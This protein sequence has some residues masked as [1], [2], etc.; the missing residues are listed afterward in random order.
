MMQTLVDC[1]EA[2]E[3]QPR[4]G[5]FYGFSGYGK[6]VAAAYAAALSG[7]IYIEAKSLWNARTVLERLA[8]E[9]GLI[10]LERTQARLLHQIID[11]INRAPRPIIIDEMDHLVKK[12][13]VDVIRDIHDATS[14]AILMIGEEALPTKLKEWD[15]F[16][17][18]ILVAQPAQPAS[19]EDALLLRNHYGLADLISDDLAMYFA[20]KCRGVT[21]RIVNNLKAAKRLANTEGVDH[22]D[23]LWWGNRPVSS[24]EIPTRRSMGA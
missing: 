21:R 3:D 5:L 7:G 8:V 23:R 9:L 24:G 1:T 14:I 11:E 15:R 12:L 22:M 19:A 13:I 6:T 17:N 16:D 4:L 10:K 20:E 18:R 2:D